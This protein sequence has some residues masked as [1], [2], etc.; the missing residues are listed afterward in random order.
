MNYDDID[1]WDN[2]SSVY[3]IS[4]DFKKLFYSVHYRYSFFFCFQKKRTKCYAC[5]FD[6][7]FENK[8][9]TKKIDL[10]KGTLIC[11]NRVNTSV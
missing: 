5:K 10:Q 9:Y 2:T 3:Y 7:R 4:F 11:G 6:R 8:K 1:I